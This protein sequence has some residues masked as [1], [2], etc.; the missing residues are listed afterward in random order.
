MSN[1]ETQNSYNKEKWFMT[2]FA[3]LRKE[4]TTIVKVD[5]FPKFQSISQSL[6]N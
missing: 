3:Y 4:S 2:H 1:S 5:Q 6:T